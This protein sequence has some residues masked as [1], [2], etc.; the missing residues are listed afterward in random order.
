MTCPGCGSDERILPLGL[1]GNR[2]H[3][4]CGCCGM[5]HSIN[6]DEDLDPAVDEIVRSPKFY[7]DVI[8]A[9]LADI[10]D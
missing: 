4:R 5:D 10:A 3:L 1:L 2:L 8:D 9:T 7:D 6:V